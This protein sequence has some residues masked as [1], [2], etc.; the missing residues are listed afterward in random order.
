MFAQFNTKGQVAA[1]LEQ[2]LFPT[3]SFTMTGL[4]DHK[5]GKTLLGLLLTVNN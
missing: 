4:L 5:S 2:E 1:M 3:I